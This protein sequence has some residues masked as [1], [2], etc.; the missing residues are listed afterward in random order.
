MITNL[1]VRDIK[2]TGAAYREVHH[3]KT[4]IAAMKTVEIYEKYKSEVI[5]CKFAMFLAIS[6][7]TY[8]KQ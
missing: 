7:D 4:E 3:I 5:I 6:L 1:A 8:S 2:T